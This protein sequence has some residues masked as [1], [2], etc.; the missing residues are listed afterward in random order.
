MP[1]RAAWRHLQ[2]QRSNAKTVGPDGQ[3]GYGAPFR[4]CDD[5]HVHDSPDGIR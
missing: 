5:D 3:I 2:R 1:K 4:R